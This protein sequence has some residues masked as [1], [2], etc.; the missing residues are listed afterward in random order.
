MIRPPTALRRALAAAAATAAVPSLAVGGYRLALLAGAALP[1]RVPPP[2]AGGPRTRFAVLVP[3]HDEAAGIAPTLR[4]ALAQAYPPGLRRVVVVADNCTDDTAGVARAAG[5]DVL[6]RRDPQRRGKGHALAWAI[7]QVL[8]DADAVVVLDAD[9]TPADDLL[10]RFDARLQAGAPGVQAD[11]RIANPGASD[12][13]ALR[14]AGFLLESTVRS[15]G[16]SRLGLSCGLHG[17]GMA[18]RADVLA[19]QPWDAFSFAEDREFHL[20]LVAAGHRVQF[21]P[22]TH[23]ASAMPATAD[24]ARSQEER[25]E[26]GRLAL[27]R[28]HLPALAAAAARRRDPAALDAALEPLLPPQALWAAMNAVALTAAAAAGSR[29]ALQ[30]AGAGCAAQAAFIAGGLAAAGTPPAVWRALAVA[31][32][33]FAGRRVGRIAAQAA[34]GGPDAWVR[35]T[36]EAA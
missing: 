12:Q 9:C 29:G 23:V 6:E 1:A 7:P 3:A 18:F 28:R 36:R 5:A 27:A 14:T 11:Y 19:A 2:A 25:W 31:G 4:A 20:R 8:G 35:T 33:A 24:A 32:P 21:A 13:A 26:S 10:A 30:L 34:G 16:R 22:E 15:G 17:T